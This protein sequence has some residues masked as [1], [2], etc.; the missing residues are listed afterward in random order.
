[1]N[2]NLSMCGASWSGRTQKQQLKDTARAVGLCVLPGERAFWINYIAHVVFLVLLWPTAVLEL[3]LY[4]GQCSG[5]VCCWSWPPARAET[6]PTLSDPRSGRRAAPQTE[7]VPPSGPRSRNRDWNP[8][9]KIAG[10]ECPPTV[11]GHTLPAILRPIFPSVK[12]DR[13]R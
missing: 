5:R 6:S 9:R 13:A 12:R 7:L 4:A 11:G 10:R 8:G 2:A 3:R 1:M